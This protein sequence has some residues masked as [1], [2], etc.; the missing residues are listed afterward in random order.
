M[1]LSD[2]LDCLSFAAMFHAVLAEHLIT[3]I[4]KMTHITWIQMRIEKTK[5][6]AELNRTHQ[7]TTKPTC[8][9]QPDHVGLNRTLNCFMR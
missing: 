7:L 8:I 2:V 1:R 5:K 3:N 9:R 4:L 6:L